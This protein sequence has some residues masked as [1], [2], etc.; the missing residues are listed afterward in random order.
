MTAEKDELLDEVSDE[1][2]R[3]DAA[4]LAQLLAKLTPPTY[5]V[6]QPWGLSAADLIT[7]RWPVPSPL[8]RALRMLD[9][10][11][12]VR[13]T[14]EGMALDGKSVDWD[15][16]LEI[17]LCSLHDALRE[18]A[19]AQTVEQLA[20]FFPPVPGRKWVLRRMAA[21]VVALA[22]RFVPESADDSPLIPLQLVRRGMLGRTVAV[23][24]GLIA[25][26]LL[27]AVPQTTEVLLHTAQVRGIPVLRPPDAP[28]A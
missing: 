24:G 13:L 7:Q 1:E 4:R 22:S 6:T 17:R 28:P 18:E 9:R 2:L 14:P 27:A 19:V 10:F 12:A 23:E 26:A 15:D 5:P 3:E 25:A 8:R 11:G 20:V 16:L 21:L